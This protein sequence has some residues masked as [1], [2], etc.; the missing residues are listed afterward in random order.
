MTSERPSR[1]VELFIVVCLGASCFASRAG[2]TKVPRPTEAELNQLVGR[3]MTSGFETVIWST[4]EPQKANLPIYAVGSPVFDAEFL[5]QIATSLGVQGKVE[6]MPADFL[7]A[8]GY[9]I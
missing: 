7:G 1:L 4:A 6:R 3:Q 2:E 8:P 5:K 9:W